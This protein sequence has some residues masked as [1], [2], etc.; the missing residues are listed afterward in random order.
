[1]SRVEERLG[2]MGVTLPNLTA[3]IAN[4]VPAKRAGSLVFT[5]YHVSA[6]EGRA[7]KGKLGATL[8]AISMKLSSMIKM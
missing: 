3:S 8:P 5:A 7:S 1:M 6:V 4:Y 2:E